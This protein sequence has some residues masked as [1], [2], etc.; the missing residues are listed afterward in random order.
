MIY[1]GIDDTDILGTRGTGRLARGIAETLGSE[2]RLLG[3][4]R[5]QLLQDPQIGRASCR[6]RV[7]YVV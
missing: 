5:H 3:V 6:E 7:C 1:I 2:H 4:V